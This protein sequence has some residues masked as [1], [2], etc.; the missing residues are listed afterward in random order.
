MNDTLSAA[1]AEA[2]LA[3]EQWTATFNTVPAPGAPT[4]H[5]GFDYEMIGRIAE[6]FRVD[7]LP[8]EMEASSSAIAM[9]RM[10]LDACAFNPLISPSLKRKMA[11]EA[12][13]T[14]GQNVIALYRRRSPLN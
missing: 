8:G 5:L 3:L 11:E 13:R 9:T 12:I 10:W 1:E 6:A 4:A 7:P 2:R 14:T